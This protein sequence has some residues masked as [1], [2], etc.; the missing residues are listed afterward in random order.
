MLYNITIHNNHKLLKDKTHKKRNKYK[1]IT[2]NNKD[3]NTKYTKRL[4]LD[5][6]AFV[7]YF[8]EGWL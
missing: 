2:K 7:F 6:D 4:I 1:R 8:I 5:F 3:K